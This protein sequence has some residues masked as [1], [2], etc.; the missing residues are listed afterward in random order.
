MVKS[1]TAYGRASTQTPAGHFVL[2]IQS[3]NRKFLE[4]NISLPPELSQFDIEIKKWLSSHLARGQVSIKVSAFFEGIVPYIVRPNIPLA[5]QLKSAWSEIAQSLGKNEQEFP[6]SLLQSQEGL[7]S[8]EHNSAA[9]ETYREILKKLLDEALKSFLLMKNQEGAVL[10][11]DIIQRLNKIRRLME[12][13]QEKTPSATKKYREKLIAR[14]DE[15]LPGHVENEERVLREV[16]LFAEKIDIMEEITR[17]FCHLQ[18]FEE[19][20]QSNTLSIGKTLDF[21]RQELN[22]EVNTVASKSS[23]RD[24]AKSVIEIKSELERIGEQIQNI[25]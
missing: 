2:E 19:L 13:I 21:I 7:F 20:L 23:D 15:I 5:Q 8:Y 3:V 6:L 18:H 4:I 16:A 25:E 11:A 1:M 14:L 10:L 24:I 22:R 12:L 9:E 17:F